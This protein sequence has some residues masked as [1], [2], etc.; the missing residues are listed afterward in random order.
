MVM[1]TRAFS[2][3]YRLVAHKPFSALRCSSG[4]SRFSNQ[5]LLT[6]KT[7][8][9][10]YTTGH[11]AAKQ[12]DYYKILGVPHDASSKRIRDAYVQVGIHDF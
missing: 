12:K 3:L 11:S 1:A 6:Y 7:V 9:S 8:R 5:N 4:F 10:I 2:N